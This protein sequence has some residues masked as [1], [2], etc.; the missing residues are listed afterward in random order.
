MF[1]TSSAPKATAPPVAGDSIYVKWKGDTT[2]Y[3]C[4]VSR[5]PVG[6]LYVK[7]ADGSFPESHGFKHDED[8]WTYPLLGDHNADN[9]RVEHHIGGG[10]GDGAGHLF[11]HGRQLRHIE[12]EVGGNL[13][14]FGR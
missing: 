13:Y 8:V 2:K 3:L 9:D 4:S 12:K 14:G 1:K 5:G 7:S 10:Q 11:C 6:G